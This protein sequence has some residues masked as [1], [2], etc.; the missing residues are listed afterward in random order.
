MPV[1][2]KKV[3]WCNAI[4]NCQ[5]G[6]LLLVLDLKVSG[7]EDVELYQWEMCIQFHSCGASTKIPTVDI[8]DRVK[9]FIIKL[10][11]HHG[12]EKFSVFTEAGKPIELETF[13]KKAPEIKAFLCYEVDEN[14][15]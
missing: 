14:F 7:Y 2:V 12:K 9:T 1:S 10:H 4:Q 15:K 8:G 11:K 3:Q 13:P 6:Q 5:N